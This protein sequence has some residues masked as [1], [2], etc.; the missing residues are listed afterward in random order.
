MTFLCLQTLDLMRIRSQRSQ[1]LPSRD[2][3]LRLPADIRERKAIARSHLLEQGT[4]ERFLH[5]QVLAD[6][7]VVYDGG[8]GCGCYLH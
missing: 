6:H 1:L 7:P 4:M 8:Q 3:L 2:V 5:L